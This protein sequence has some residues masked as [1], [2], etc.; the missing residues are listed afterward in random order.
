MS[1]WFLRN[2]DRPGRFRGGQI[3]GQAFELRD[4]ESGLSLTRLP[5]DKDEWAEFIDDVWKG[6]MLLHGDRPALT[7][8]SQE[9]IEELGLE[10]QH[11]PVD[12]NEEH[13]EILGITDG[14]PDQLALHSTKAGMVAPFLT[15]KGK[16][17]EPDE[18][19]RSSMYR[20]P[21]SEDP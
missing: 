7:L 14:H 15:R 8:V 3:D 18:A 5:S 4:G 12:G 9:A 19:L 1:R 6:N 16:L 2:I 20:K 21:E 13:F 17:R 10:L 11:S